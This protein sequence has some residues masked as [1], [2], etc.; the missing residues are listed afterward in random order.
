MINVDFDRFAIAVEIRSDAWK[1]YKFRN[2][3]HYC[4]EDCS[5]SL[6]CVI[7]QTCHCD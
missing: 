2:W 3:R 7:V 6:F 4:S 1:Y 5:I